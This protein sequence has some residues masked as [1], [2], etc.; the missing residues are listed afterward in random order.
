MAAVAGCTVD[1]VAQMRFVRIDV[2]LGLFIQISNITGVAIHA[3]L[4]FNRLVVIHRDFGGFTVALV[5]FNL[6]LLVQ[7]GQRLH[8]AGILGRRHSHRRGSKK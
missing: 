1:G 3:H 5:A 2:A 8:S 7:S 4:V 6:A